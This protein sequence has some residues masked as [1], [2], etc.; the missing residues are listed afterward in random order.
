VHAYDQWSV[1]DLLQ[2]AGRHIQPSDHR[3]RT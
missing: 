2:L 1:D 3:L